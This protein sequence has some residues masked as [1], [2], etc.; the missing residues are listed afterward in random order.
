MSVKCLLFISS[1]F[2]LLNEFLTYFGNAG[3]WFIAFL[4]NVG[5]SLHKKCYKL[6]VDIWLELDLY[7]TMN[8]I[9]LEEHSFSVSFVISDSILVWDVLTDIMF[10][11]VLFWLFFSNGITKK[12]S[13]NIKNMDPLIANRILFTNIIHTLTLLS[14]WNLFIYIGGIFLGLLFNFHSWV[15]KY[16]FQLLIY[17]SLQ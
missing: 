14:L 8:A 13:K 12:Y 11:E 6:K 7:G 16:M 5:N 1:M 9:K 4:K 10:L 17:L 3:I 2:Y 15:C